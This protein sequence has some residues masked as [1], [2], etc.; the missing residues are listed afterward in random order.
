MK[1]VNPQ[2]GECVEGMGLAI[3]VLAFPAATK[4]SP[5]PGAVFADFRVHGSRRPFSDA[6]PSVCTYY[7]K[8]QSRG[9]AG[10]AEEEP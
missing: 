1:M 7:R 8:R 10:S 9:F 4:P 6:S 2:L 5:R 3:N